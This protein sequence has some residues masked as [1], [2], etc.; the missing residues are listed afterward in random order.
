MLAFHDPVSQN[1]KETWFGRVSTWHPH[2]IYRLYMDMEL[3]EERIPKPP[4]F[5]VSDDNL[6]S[7]VR[8]QS[9]TV[10]KTVYGPVS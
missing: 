10:L 4:V 6:W 9:Y 5:V 2:V 7:V 3:R 1:V 8:I